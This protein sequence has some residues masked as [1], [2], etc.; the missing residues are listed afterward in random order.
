M[1]GFD[2]VVQHVEYGVA[3]QPAALALPPALA[4]SAMAEGG[5]EQIRRGRS[6]DQPILGGAQNSPPSV[7]EHIAVSYT[8]VRRTE[9]RILG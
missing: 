1:T 3:A 5:P 8:A 2:A 6:H 4:V 9:G 7:G